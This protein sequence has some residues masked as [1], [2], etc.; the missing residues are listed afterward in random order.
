ADDG[1][2][3]GRASGRHVL[4][5]EQYDRQQREADPQGVAERVAAA[6]VQQAE[7]ERGAD[8]A[9]AEGPDGLGEVHVRRA[10]RIPG[11][12]DQQRRQQPRAG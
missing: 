9:H 10:E 8:G 1:R 2:A 7:Q 4:V 11:A 12:D 3:R 6:H 5:R